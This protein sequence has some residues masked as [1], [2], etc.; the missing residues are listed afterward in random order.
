MTKLKNS[1]CNKTRDSNC[2]LTQTVKK[3]T[4]KKCDKTQIVTKLKNSKC[5][6]LKKTQI[7][8]EKL[9]N[10][11]CD[12]TWNTTNLNLWIKN[13]NGSF[14]KNIL[15]TWQPM[16][17]SLKKKQER[18]NKTAKVGLLKLTTPKYESLNAVW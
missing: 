5:D 4:T 16:R 6:K 8:R 9:K 10:S 1:N 3:E 17:C 15:T 2:D 7:T 14:I 11:I 12:K 18:Y 13:F